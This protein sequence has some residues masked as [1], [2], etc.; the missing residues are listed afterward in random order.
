M[1]RLKHLTILAIVLLTA[2]FA[3][4]QTV[5]FQSEN[6]SSETFD[7]DNLQS[8]VYSNNNL[9]LNSTTETTSF[10]NILFCQKIYF[11]GSFSSIQETSTHAGTPVIFPNPASTSISVDID[12]A[13][14]ADVTIYDVMGN[15]VLQTSISNYTHKIN[16]SSLPAG[17]YFLVINNQSSKFIK[18]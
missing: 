18:Q 17:L 16:I 12:I 14:Q 10:L 11:D 8:L 7:L 13:N 2:H 1:N 5:V 15:K 3:T 4:A 6:G 9:A